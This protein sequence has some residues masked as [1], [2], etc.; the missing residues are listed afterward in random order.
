MKTFICHA[1]LFDLDGTLVN[2]LESVEQSWGRWKREQGIPDQPLSHGLTAVETVRRFT[3][4]LDPQV[5]L[6]KLEQYENELVHLVTPMPGARPL[7]TSLPADRWGIVTSGTR[8]IAVPRIEQTNLPMPRV[9]V[10]ADQ[11]AQGKPHPEPYLLGAERLGVA[12][13]NCLVIEDTINGIQA[14]LAAGMRC[15]GVSGAD[16]VTAVSIAQATIPNVSYLAI[17][18]LADGTLQV[19][20]TDTPVPAE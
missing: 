1:I 3:P 12:P 4:H 9:L 8:P 20:C 14:G 7:L 17:E 19:R 5:E 10:T 16:G 2:S 15:I 6:P 18:Q 11:V 13:G